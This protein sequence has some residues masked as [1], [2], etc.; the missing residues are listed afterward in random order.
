MKDEVEK[1]LKYISDIKLPIIELSDS[2]FYS[3]MALCV[4]DAVYSIGVK[5]AGV[6]NVVKS[7][8]NYKKVEIENIHRSRVQSLSDYNSTYTLG[9]FIS[10]LEENEPEYNAKN[11]FK[12]SQRT[13]TRNGILKAEAVLL[14]AKS[15]HNH[16]IIDFRSLIKIDVNDKTLRL[17]ECEI[18]EIPGQ[19]S[20]ISFQYFLMLAGDDNQIKP[21]RMVIRF[22][23]E[24]LKR[25][26]T[27]EN[28]SE[29][30]INTANNLGIAPRKLDHSVWSYQRAL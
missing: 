20:G 15:L 14:F 26:I 6:K 19:K 7:F 17:A 4:V 13:S 30:L 27:S 8:Q 5:Y 24:C 29:I 18:K 16:N 25:E 9:N 23:K 3:S 22:L 11:I 2:Y 12:N 21:D 28:A 1:V 10:L